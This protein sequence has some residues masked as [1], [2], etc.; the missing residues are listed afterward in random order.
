MFSD[1]IVACR[2][3][4][5]GETPGISKSDQVGFA[6]EEVDIEDS[7]QCDLFSRHGGFIKSHS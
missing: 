4:Q 5:D 1:E 6:G 2:V 3:K 7:K